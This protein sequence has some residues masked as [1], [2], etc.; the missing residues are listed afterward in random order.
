MS[1]PPLQWW[2]A[3]SAKVAS[4]NLDRAGDDAGAAAEAGEPGPLARVVALT[5]LRLVF[6]DV[7]PARR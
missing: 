6:A 5:T 2:R 7:V 3:N 1:R 4:T